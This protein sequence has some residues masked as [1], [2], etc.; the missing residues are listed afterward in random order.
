MNFAGELM[1]KETIAAL[2]VAVVATLLCMTLLLFEKIGEASFSA[3]ITLVAILSFA[4]YS[5]SRLRE[6][7]LGNLKV[8]LDRIETVKRE[9]TEVK[10]EIQEMYG[11]IEN[12]KRA[13]LV[14]D[15]A[16]MAELGVEGNGF[17][18]TSAVM[19]YPVG[20]MKRERERLARILVTNPDMK[21][22][23]DAILDNSLDDLVFK[24]A[25]PE[26]ALDD[27]PVSVEERARRKAAGTDS[28]PTSPTP[29]S[30]S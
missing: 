10:Q 12:L 25:G 4:I 15:R 20:C 17:P 7:D 21:W 14:L 29:S 30:P 18:A 6:L 5:F 3:L 8:T 28:P 23:A 19:R 26:A 13:P 24:W 27:V 2:V 22:L 16:K 9:V 1:R 11:G